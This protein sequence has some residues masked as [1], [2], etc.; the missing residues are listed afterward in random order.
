[1]LEDRFSELKNVDV[2]EIH[3]LHRANNADASRPRNARMR[4]TI[5]TICYMSQNKWSGKIITFRWPSSVAV[6]VVFEE[7][8]FRSTSISAERTRYIRNDLINCEVSYVGYHSWNIYVCTY[9]CSQMM[10]KL[11]VEKR[12]VR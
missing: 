7:E 8:S 5:R 9:I 6:C 10:I 1:M 4:N 11:N 12:K 3:I 2:A